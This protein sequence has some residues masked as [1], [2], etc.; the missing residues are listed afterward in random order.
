MDVIICFWVIISCMLIIAIKCETIMSSFQ[1]HVSESLNMESFGINVTPAIYM[2]SI[3]SY[4]DYNMIQSLIN[5]LQQR[6]CVTVVVIGGSICAGHGTPRNAETAFTT[7]LTDF[8]NENLPCNETIS[9]E[10]RGRHVSYNECLGGEGSG[11][12]IDFFMEV[13]SIQT[14]TSDNNITQNN[15][16]GNHKKR[17]RTVFEEHVSSADLV[18]VDTSCNDAVTELVANNRY[19]D[20]QD[21]TYAQ[22]LME[23]LIIMTV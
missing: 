14:N 18:L 22:K 8:L 3:Q 10:S 1:S 2:R 7:K 12:F 13:N 9:E 4:G 11:A 23:I 15:D 21:A 20:G 16:S 5:P 17:Y 6:R 19:V